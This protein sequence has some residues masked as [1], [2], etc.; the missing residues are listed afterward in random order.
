M[1]VQFILD[2]FGVDCTDAVEVKPSIQS[3]LK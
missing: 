3:F 2:Y 1:S